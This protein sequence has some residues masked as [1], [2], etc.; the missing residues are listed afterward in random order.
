ML[1]LK[2]RS[3]AYAGWNFSCTNKNDTGRF[4]PLADHKLNNRMNWLR[5]NWFMAALISC[6]GVGFWLTD[7]LHALT[8]SGW[9]KWTIVSL[10]MVAMTW[11]LKTSSLVSAAANP[12]PAILASTINLVAAPLLAWPLSQFLSDDMA[13]GLLLAAA[14]PSTLASAA[15]WTRRAG[16]NDSVAM[17]VTIITNAICFL[18]T[19][20]WVFWLIGQQITG[21][22]VSDTIF[23]LLLFVVLPMAV[24]QALRV[25]SGLAQWAT[26]NKPKFSLFAQIGI[27][28][29]VLL[30]SIKM[31]QTLEFASIYMITNQLLL[32]IVLVS[33]LH[34]ALFSMGIYA[35]RATGQNRENN[36]AIGFSGS[37]KTLMVGLSVAVSM[38]L[39]IIPIVAYHAMQLIIDTLIADRYRQV[40]PSDHTEE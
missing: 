40:L 19:P 18:V 5:Q 3:P 13:A 37:Q 2:H 35:G 39:N 33:S 12:I 15:V 27:L 11:P 7:P 6:L 8:D 9:V 21:F 25:P 36:I 10:T 31:G 4:V 23:K 24:G 26:N 32:V 22:D 38:G 14:A 30:G 34:L 17:M 29:M 28:A 16:G 1:R 20:A